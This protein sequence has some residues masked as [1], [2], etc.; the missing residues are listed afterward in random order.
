MAGAKQREA[1]RAVEARRLIAA[2]DERTL[3]IALHFFVAGMT[4]H[5]IAA[6]TG[7]DRRTGG[8]RL[9][10]FRSRTEDLND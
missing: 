10:Q 7:V 4:Q 9:R 3:T 2:S 1:T 5:E 6:V 8:K